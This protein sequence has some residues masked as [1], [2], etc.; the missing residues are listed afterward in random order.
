[1]QTMP[2]GLRRKAQP[3]Q[4]LAPKF[5]SYRI[6]IA[7]DFAKVAKSALLNLA[8]YEAIYEIMGGLGGMVGLKNYSL[9]S[10]PPVNVH[11][12]VR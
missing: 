8:I 6:S 7:T 5:L 1:M 10:A 4:D 9:P 3:V 11:S 2:H 12:Q